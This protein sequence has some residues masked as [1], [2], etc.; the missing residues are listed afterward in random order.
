MVFPII[1]GS[2]FRVFDESDD[3]TTLSLVDTRTYDN[4]ILVLTYQ[5]AQETGA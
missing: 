1:L 2:G 5:T 3:A 4:G